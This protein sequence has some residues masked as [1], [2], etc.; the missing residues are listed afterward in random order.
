MFALSEFIE[1][2]TNNILQQ[3]RLREDK[4]RTNSP[5]QRRQDAKVGRKKYEGQRTIH[6]RS[7]SLAAL[8]PFREKFRIRSLHIKQPFGKSFNGVH[9]S[10]LF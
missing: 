6:H 8:A 9:L 7:P 4:I 5:L 1:A 10:A 3:S 2:N